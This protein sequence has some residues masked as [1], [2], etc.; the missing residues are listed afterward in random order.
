MRKRTSENGKLRLKKEAIRFLG[1]SLKTAA[2]GA[3]PVPNSA[4]CSIDCGCTETG[5]TNSPE[6]SY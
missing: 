5:C 2:G 1:K 6:I 3:R 4:T